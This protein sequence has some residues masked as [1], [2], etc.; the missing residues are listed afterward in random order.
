MSY[1]AA[2]NASLPLG[3]SSNCGVTICRSVATGSA[4]F[5]ATLDESVQGAYLV[6]ALN[7]SSEV[8]S[9]I[10]MTLT[11]ANDGGNFTSSFQFPGN[12]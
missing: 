11:G 6:V 12:G 5:N 7:H 10:H 2:A 1:A 8:V 9:C 3:I 4:L